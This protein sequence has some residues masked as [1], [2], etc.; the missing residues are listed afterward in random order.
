MGFFSLW[1]ASSGNGADLGC[2]CDL[3]ND[4]EHRDLIRAFVRTIAARFGDRCE[5]GK[6][7]FNEDLIDIDTSVFNASRGSRTVYGTMKGKGD[8]LRE[9]QGPDCPARPHR[10]SRFIQAPADVD[11]VPVETIRGV[12][13]DC[14]STNPVTVEMPG[15]D[16]GRV[17][18]YP[19]TSVSQVGVTKIRPEAPCNRSRR[20]GSRRSWSST[21]A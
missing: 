7:P 1:L 17:S 5:K 11:D 16:D 10:L 15:G 8:D 20:N 19:P 13:S 21:P 3:P 2:G 14:R 9:D 18:R 12:V 4:D 6:T